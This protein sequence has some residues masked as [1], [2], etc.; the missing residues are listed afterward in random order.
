MSARVVSGVRM[1]QTTRSQTSFRIL[2]PSHNFTCGTRSP[3]EYRSA[4]SGL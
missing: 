1:L 3:S 4:A 2:P